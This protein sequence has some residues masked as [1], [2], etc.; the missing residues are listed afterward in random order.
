MRKDDPATYPKWLRRKL[1]QME[2]EKAR[3]CKVGQEFKARLDG[4]KSTAQNLQEAT[5]TITITSIEGGI[6]ICHEGRWKK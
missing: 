5:W 6:R 4:L 3:C 1:A 2:D